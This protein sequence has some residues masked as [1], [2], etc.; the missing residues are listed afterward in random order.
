ML[1]WGQANGRNFKYHPCNNTLGFRNYPGGPPMYPSAYWGQ[2]D[3]EMVEEFC[4]ALRPCLLKQRLRSMAVQIVISIQSN[5]HRRTR[6]KRK[7]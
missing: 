5:S 4:A 6:M 1:Q 7:T 2:Q 3:P